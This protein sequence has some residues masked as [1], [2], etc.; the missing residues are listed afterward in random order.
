MLNRLDLF[1]HTVHMSLSGVY[2]L[3]PFEYLVIYINIYAIHV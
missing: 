2:F 1:F 3:Q